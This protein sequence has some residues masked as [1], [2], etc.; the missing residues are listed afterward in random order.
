MQ[1]V[2][3]G[4]AALLEEYDRTTSGRL[5]LV[6]AVLALV[7]FL[8]LAV[9]FRSPFLAG[10][11]VALNLL[12]GAA[13]LGALVLLFQGAA[14]LGGPGYLDA[15]AAVG[16]FTVLFGLSTDYQLF[17]LT[18]MR[19][20]FAETGDARV[21]VRDGLRRTA[22]VVGGAAFAMTAVFLAFAPAE[23]INVRQFGV[24]LAIAVILDATV[25]RLVLLPAVLTL[26]GPRAWGRR[27]LRPPEG[28]A[29]SS[30]G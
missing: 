20:R 19:E 13:T 29:A 2:V 23:A 5:W 16:I 21:A 17:L 8:L 6:V 4:P 11:A 12:T 15:T 7:T 9:I 26:A 24:G 10:A 30:S 1:V 28:P 18:R 3:G 25:V 14:P 27:P 22:R